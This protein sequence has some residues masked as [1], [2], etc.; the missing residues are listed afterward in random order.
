[1]RGL[2]RLDGQKK[3]SNGGMQTLDHRSEL[4]QELNRFRA[5]ENSLP[6]EGI[7]GDFRNEPF[8]TLP[9]TDPAIAEWTGTAPTE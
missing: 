8:P 2:Q 3:S 7:P 1:M 9:N 5:I 4:E 6:S